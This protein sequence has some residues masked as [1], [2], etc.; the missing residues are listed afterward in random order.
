[1]I[2][3]WHI[4][5]WIVLIGAL[6]ASASASLG[7]FL[8]LRRMSLVGDAISHSVLPGIAAAFLFTGERASWTVFLGAAATGLLTVWI[9]ELVRRYGKVEESAAIGI[10]FT[11]MFAL[12]LV[13]VVRAGDHVDLDPMCIL[14]GNLELVFL[15]TIP[16]QIGEIPRAV[17]TLGGVLLL[18]LTTIALFYKEWKITT[19]DPAYARSQ[20]VPSGLFHYLLASLV[21]ITCVAA[22]EAVGNILVV[23][24]IIVPAAISFLWTCR[25][26]TML[27]LS[28]S[29]AVLIAILGHISAIW[30]PHLFGH[31]SIN[32]AASMA[33]VSGLLL[34]LTVLFAPGS[35]LV[36]RW[37]RQRALAHQI[38]LD[39]VL[40][41][42][43]RQR[44][45][46]ESIQGDQEG[47]PFLAIAEKLH[48]SMG[49]L[50]G[51]LDRLSQSKMISIAPNGATLTDSGLKHAQ[52][53]VR[54]HR[55][56]EQYLAVETSLTEDKV[57]P[58]AESWEHFTSPSM[59]GEL[60]NVTG[61]A[62]TDPHGKSIPPEG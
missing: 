62:P 32:S 49:R 2:W 60:D 43:Y 51:V 57:H 11:T 37:I 21:A 30:L 18:N 39:D 35:G 1:M 58:H 54:S 3:D 15:D 36:S 13:L 53:L 17:L 10:V 48:I 52:N 47:T 20:G 7:V 59:R 34:G 55:L 14:Y 41:F 8:L 61:N 27:L 5:G 4:D 22:F 24:V 46:G 56:W 28:I 16:T 40:A 45:V 33:V 44:E 42:L 29:F 50:M 9:S 31:R 38:L 12:G 25:L 19:F 6:A 26:S 23:A